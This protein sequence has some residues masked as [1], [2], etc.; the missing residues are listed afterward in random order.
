MLAMPT[1]NSTPYVR[2]R[3]IT[4]PSTNTQ[5]TT[6]KKRTH[7]RMKTSELDAKRSDRITRPQQAMLP[8]NISKYVVRDAEAVTNLGW[9]Y[10]VRRRRG[11]GDFASLSEVEHLARRLL[12]QYKHHGVPVVLMT[13]EWS[14]GEHLAALKVGTAQGCHRTRPFSP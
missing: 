13:L 11:C 10:F 14:E 2:T 3:A 5:S 12:R 1:T 4:T 8:E 7:L 9:K 6:I